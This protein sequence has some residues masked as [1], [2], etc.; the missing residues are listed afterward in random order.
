MMWPLVPAPGRSRPSTCTTKWAPPVPRPRS[1]AVV[2]IAT[3]SPTPATAVT[4]PGKAFPLQLARKRKNAGDLPPDHLLRRYCF[5]ERLPVPGAA[6]LLAPAAAAPGTRT[7]AALAVLA[8]IAAV[9]FGLTHG[10]FGGQGFGREGVLAGQ[11]DAPQL[12]DLLH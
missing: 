9:A 8:L 4:S 7:P 3:R 11:V 12:V 5:N 1:T 2:L 10:L 6:P